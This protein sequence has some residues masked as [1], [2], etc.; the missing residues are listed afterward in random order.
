MIAVI[1]EDL[2]KSL[3][4]ILLSLD[5]TVY[6]IRDS[7]LQGSSDNKVWSFT[8]RKKAI[9][10]TGDLGF[11]NILRFPLGSHSGICILRYPNEM[12][13]DLINKNIKK[14]LVKLTPE[15]YQGNLVIISWDKIRIR[16]LEQSRS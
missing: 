7:G 3:K 14:L 13:I 4:E 1:D 16:R 15:D 6:D 2:H 10:F 5:F 9:L 8:Q 12:P 11:S